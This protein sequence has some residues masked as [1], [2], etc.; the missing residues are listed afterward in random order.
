LRSNSSERHRKWN[1]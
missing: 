1:C